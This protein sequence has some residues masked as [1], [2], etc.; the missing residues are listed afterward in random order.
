MLD[1][2]TLG[3]HVC[4]TVDGDVERSMV[5]AGYVRAGLRHRH[6]IVYRGDTPAAVL[7]GLDRMGI[8]TAAAMASGQ[9]LVNTPE[10]ALVVDGTFDAE[11]ALARWRVGSAR[12]RAA[13]YGGLRLI[14]DMSW[15]A[16]PVPGAERLAWYEAEV[17]TIYAEGDAMAL[18]L[19]DRRL[20]EPFE[21]RRLAWSH[22]GTMGGTVPFDPGSSLRLRWT[23]EPFGVR[24]EGEADLSNRCALSAVLEHLVDRRPA[25]AVATIDV[26]GLRF[27]DSSVA[28]ALINAGSA[29]AGRIRLV[30]CSPGI[31][32]LLDLNGADSAA[33]FTIAR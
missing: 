5:L 12:S 26:T 15:A 30:G 24:L 20:F 18:C 13:G 19:Y 22:P 16:G 8:D 1:R 27:A 23:R 33:G 32:R 6:Q 14:T 2:L 28:R 7:A 17:T 25:G 10:S 31:S 3:D 11:A 9:L 4:W 21:L 29:G